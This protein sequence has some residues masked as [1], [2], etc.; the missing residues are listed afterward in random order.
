MVTQSLSTIT[1][2]TKQAL[3]NAKNE[4]LQRIDKTASQNRDETRELYDQ[5]SDNLGEY[6]KLIDEERRRR[7]ANRESERRNG[8]KRQPTEIERDKAFSV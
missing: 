4:N 1:T 6:A 8:L 5:A 2:T 7:D 3:E